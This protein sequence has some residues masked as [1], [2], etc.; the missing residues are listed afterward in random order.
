MKKWENKG[1]DKY[2][3]EER[4]RDMKRRVERGKERIELDGK[5]KKEK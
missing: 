3:E 1:I 4:G 2:G 5:R